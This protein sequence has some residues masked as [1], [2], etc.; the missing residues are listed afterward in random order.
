M[1]KKT[2]Q[3]P[4]PAATPPDLETEVANRLRDPFEQNYMGV[5]QTADPL[6][7]EKGDP[8]GEIYRDLK[9][10]GKVF[11]GLQKRKLALVGR[12]WQVVPVQDGD[13]QSADAEIVSGILKRCSFDQVC[14]DLMDA[15]LR[16]YAVSEIVWTVRDGYYV[17]AR[18]VK[19]AQRRFK[20][21]QAAEHQPPELR[22]LTKANML[23]GEALPPRKFIVHTVN[24]ED[25][26]PYG[27]G[28]GLQ[29]YWPVFFK[30]K[31]IIAWNKLNDRFGSPTPWGKYPRNA[32][33]KEK[34]T[35][36]AALKAISNDGV[37]ITP[38]GTSIELL[39]TKLTGSVTTQ[40]ALCQYMDD[41]IAE[42]LLGQEPRAGSGGAL[43]AASKERTAVR[44]DLVQADSDLLSATLNE[45]L[46]LWICELN[47]LAPCQVSREISE[48]E[49]KKAESE[50][51]VNVAGMGFELSEDAV[52]EKYGEGWSKKIPG[53]TDTPPGDAG[54]PQDPAAKQPGPTGA[55]DA[56]KF[57]A[58][59]INAYSMGIDRL[60]QLRLEVPEDFVRGLFSIPKPAGGEAVLKSRGQGQVQG[61]PGQ[62]LDPNKPAN[63]SEM[64]TT[65]GIDLLVEEALSDWKPMMQPF[66]DPLQ[67][68]LDASVAA[69]E[70]AEQFLAR[71]PEVLARMDPAQLLAALAKAA[72]T[73]R[74]AGNAG[75]GNAE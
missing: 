61:D 54:G 45:T 35:L 67:A 50:T 27:T 34:A 17:P 13:A 64:A 62:Q 28:L 40:Q 14:Q 19:R 3:R 39:E 66:A 43:A 53:P 63:F 29:L 55:A 72:F 68:A 18:I 74:L 56:Q 37:V 11:S 15:L 4:A 16:G 10:D 33:P 12:E 9:R 42:V 36:F 30:R 41:W 49:D 60:S 44:L 51:D 25:D 48:E 21:V 47:G 59:M 20:Y 6:L 69:G 22:L 57:D 58:S 70:T 23:T 73:S 38:E 31:G 65:D 52:R 8:A 1:A 46:L 26:N 71:L 24:A 2:R 75:V 5:I 7:L 32:V